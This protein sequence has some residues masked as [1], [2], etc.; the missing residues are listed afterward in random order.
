MAR[1]AP[2]WNIVCVV[3]PQPP[4]PSDGATPEFVVRKLPIPAAVLDESGTVRVANP[5]F[6][7]MAARLELPGTFDRSFDQVVEEERGTCCHAFRIVHVAMGPSVP[8]IVLVEDVTDLV[9]EMDRNAPYPANLPARIAPFVLAEHLRCPRL[10]ND[11][12]EALWHP[13]VVLRPPQGTVATANAPARGIP[14]LALGSV[15]APTD[16]GSIL[17]GSRGAVRLP[18][19]QWCDLFGYRFVIL[20]TTCFDDGL[21]RSGNPTTIPPRPAPLGQA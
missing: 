12:A 5:D 11:L 15:L 20:Q 8:D 4:C 7:A 9:F 19:E 18:V 16:D 13:T 21:T 1:V 10:L 2:A 6:E 17:V 3:L 14:S